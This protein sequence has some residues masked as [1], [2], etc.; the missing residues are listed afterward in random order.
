MVLNI[1]WHDSNLVAINKPPGLLVHRTP[2]AKE[3][4]TFAVQLLRDQLG[5]RVYP[6]HRLDR[7]TGGVLLFALNQSIGKAMHLAFSK[8][9]IEKTYLAIV[10][11]F[12]EPEGL[13]DHPLRKENGMMQESK[14][15]Y[16]T[17]ANPRSTCHLEHIAHRAT[18]YWKSRL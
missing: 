1:I 5:R 3:S 4:E 9:L 18:P 13:I 11:G 15:L 2:L 16:K 14:T 6:V 7:K 10:R 8:R 17:L 12:T